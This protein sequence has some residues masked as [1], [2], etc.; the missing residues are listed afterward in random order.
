MKKLATF[1]ALLSLVFSIAACNKTSSCPSEATLIE[2]IELGDFTKRLM[3]YDTL[4]RLTFVDSVGQE[5]IFRKVSQVGLDE[6]LRASDWST[7]AFQD[8]EGEVELFYNTEWREYRFETDAGDSL[9]V[10]FR[11]HPGSLGYRVTSD[12]PLD[13]YSSWDRL[14][15]ELNLASCEEPLIEKYQLEFKEPDG[16]SRISGFLIFE[17]YRVGAIS[18]EPITYFNQFSLLSDFVFSTRRC[19]IGFSSCDENRWILKEQE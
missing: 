17:P 18:Y 6:P 3:V 5:K 19:L 10:R 7:D 12:L 1:F 14:Y 11:G 15:V 2:L 16:S 4:T 9:L 13:E 8:C